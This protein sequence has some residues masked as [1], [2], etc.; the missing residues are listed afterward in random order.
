MRGSMINLGHEQRGWW[1]NSDIICSLET[2]RKQHNWEEVQ[3]GVS[4]QA[5]VIHD[6]QFRRQHIYDRQEE[7]AWMLIVLVCSVLT[8]YVQQI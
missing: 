8:V 4:I 1:I 2:N 5:A 6:S 3:T 7:C